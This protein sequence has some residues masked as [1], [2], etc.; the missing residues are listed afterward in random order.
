[1]EESAR[2]STIVLYYRIMSGTQ[3]PSESGAV[4]TVERR[5]QRGSGGILQVGDQVWRVD[6]ELA[7]DSVTTR[8]R[9]VSR[10][11]RGTREEAELALA[12]LKV[13]GHE[14][15]LPSGGTN[16]RSVSGAL[17]LY[18]Q[19]AESGL[20]ELAPRTVI[21][22][23]SAIKV[24]GS[25]ELPDGRKFG[26]IP[27]SR[28]TW[29]DIEHLYGAMRVSG[30]GPEW[31][32]RCA[33]VLTRALDLAR[34]RGLIDA[35]PSKDAVRPKSVRK[36]PFAPSE[37]EVRKVLTTVAAKD[38]QMANL[39]TVLASTGMRTGEVL[40]LQWADVKL[41]AGEVH[42]AAAI[43]DGGPGVGVVR[44]STKRADW[45]D[46]PLTGAALSALQRQADRYEKLFG[47]PAPPTAYIFGGSPDGVDPL[48]PDGL[49]HG[50]AQS[51]GKSTL[52]LL[53]LRHYVATAMLDAGES[54]RTVA[55][56][57]GNSEATLRLH[58]DGRTGIEKR[59]AIT[60]LE[61]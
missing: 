41:E 30:R 7:R 50:W 22:S 42:V 54:Y 26:A 60:A 59:K 17:E 9:R 35:N 14:K 48:R 24:M 20:L 58:Y 10:T 38:P 27:L 56:I 15:R 44:K 31:I 1:M 13:A 8:R 29:Q 19:T 18:L 2:R 52:T 36:K 16:A 11:V 6:V 57:L 4:R 53:D 51:R 40:G 46:V 55:D 21:T 45:R 49:S 3:K 32:R 12:R 43:T 25:T 39:A 23:K 61:L 33:T 47:Q 34:K 37:A 28:L 5:R